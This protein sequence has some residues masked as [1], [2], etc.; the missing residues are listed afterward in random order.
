MGLKSV[1]KGLLPDALLSRLGLV[2]SISQFAF[3]PSQDVK[4]D[5]QRKY[6]FD[7][8]LLEYFVSNSGAVV[9]KWHHYIPVYD[10]YF[11]RFR[12]RQVRFLEI[13]VS[14]G[15]SLQVWRQ[16][17]GPDAVIYGIDIDPACSQFDGAAGRVRIGSQDDPAFLASVV[18]EMGGVDVVLDDGSHRMDH[19]R[20]TFGFLFPRLSDGGVY[21]VEDLHTAYWEDFGGGYRAEANFFG[22]ISELVDD[23][24][25]WYHRHE[26]THAALSG[27]CAGIHIHDSIAV[28]EKATVYPPTHSR[29]G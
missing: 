27:V 24:H 11:S 28:L 9:H 10:R 23:M 15:G 16:Y 29:I 5:I 6:G 17:F 8:D 1:A 3:D 7:G 14:K 12:G 20:S 2:D 22:F 19:V 4:A 26:V 18:A 25:H 21:L 13:G